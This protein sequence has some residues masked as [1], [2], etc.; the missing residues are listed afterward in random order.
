MEEETVEYNQELADLNMKENTFPEVDEKEEGIGE[1][2]ETD[3]FYQ[4]GV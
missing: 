1:V 2:K 3:E 4:G